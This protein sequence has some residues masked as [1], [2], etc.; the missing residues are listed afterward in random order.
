MLRTEIE[1]QHNEIWD[2][3]KE[4]DLHAYEKEILETEL[5]LARKQLNDADQNIIGLEKE[6]DTEKN[7]I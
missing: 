5:E 4:R 3:T 7:T 6:I 2:L 1:Q